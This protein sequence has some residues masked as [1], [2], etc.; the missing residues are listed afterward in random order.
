MSQYFS[1]LAE[2]SGVAT[3]AQALQT[4]SA[5]SNETTAWGEQSS[6]VIAQPGP[7]VT[8]S[9]VEN[10][11]SIG[12][13]ANV[14]T[15]TFSVDVTT[16]MPDKH[17]RVIANSSSISEPS[18]IAPN[19][20]E[21]DFGSPLH[22]THSLPRES[23][24][25]GEMSTASDPVVSSGNAINHD[26]GEH[27]TIIAKPSGQRI[28]ENST[29]A[30]HQPSESMGL[31]TALVSTAPNTSPVETDNNI[32]TRSMNSDTSSTEWSESNKTLPSSREPNKVQSTARIA[33][34]P[35]QTVTDGEI[36]SRS[37]SRSSVQVSIGR[38][39]LEIHAPAKPAVRAPQAARA[40]A[41]PPKTPARTSAF[42]PHRHY[43]RSR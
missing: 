36:A 11:N 32:K 25:V 39:E 29:S 9:R 37:S 17:R 7:F 22:T 38:I 10:S 13:P 27:N 34:Q 4:K 23:S 5:R 35:A 2:R 28:K 1:R 16:E 3:S 43:L 24:M 19:D 33:A 15:E 42:N 8:G 14:S 18:R 30:I 20:I 21:S 40:S 12:Q 31:D 41:A 6:E 26:I